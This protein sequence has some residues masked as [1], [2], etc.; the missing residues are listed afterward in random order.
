MG[1]LYSVF[2][3]FLKKQNA[4]DTSHMEAN[5]EEEYEEEYE[6]M[7]Y[8]E[9]SAILDTKSGIVYSRGNEVL[10]IEILKEFL[11]VYSNNFEQFKEYIENEEYDNVLSLA[12]DMSGLAGAI[13]ANNMTHLLSE[14]NQL[15]IYGAQKQLSLYIDGYKKEL[16]YLTNQIQQYIESQQG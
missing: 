14:I 11:E 13:G 5:E 6:P 1:Q 15:F 9:D 12:R 16:E 2:S 3:L 10:Y 7:D 4:L 8:I